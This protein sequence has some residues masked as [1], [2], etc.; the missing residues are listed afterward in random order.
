MVDDRADLPGATWLATAERIQRGLNHD[1]SNRTA[2]LAAVVALCDS[3]DHDLLARLEEEVE[4]LGTLLRHM[5]LLP[6]VPN[7]PA[8]PVLAD[9]VMPDVLALIGGIAEFRDVVVRVAPLGSVP[10]LRCRPQALQHALLLLLVAVGDAGGNLTLDVTHD[11][12]AVTF[13][14]GTSAGSPLDAPGSGD[15]VADAAVHRLGGDGALVWA[16]GPGYRLRLPTLT[17]LRARARVRA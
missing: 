8:E 6:R 7:A 4:R 3:T 1:L 9:D 13:G 11:E 5:R 10:P 15:A 2:A 17:A 12:V 16:V 14:I